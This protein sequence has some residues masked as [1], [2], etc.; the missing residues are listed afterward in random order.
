MHADT[1]SISS[2]PAYQLALSGVTGTNASGA[3][4][5]ILTA[6]ATSANVA[7]ARA[8]GVP[9][10]MPGGDSGFF[11]TAVATTKPSTASLTL[12]QALVAFPQYSGV[13]D[14]WGSNVENFSYN[15]LQVTVRQRLS[16]GLTFNANYT[17]SQNLGDDGSFR[18]GFRDS[19]WYGRRHD[20]ESFRQNRIDRGVTTIAQPHVFNFFG[21]Y[22]IPVGMHGHFLGENVITRSLFGNWSLSGI[23]QAASGTPVAVTSS[24]CTSTPPN[25]GTCMPSIAPGKTSARINGAYGSGPGGTTFS[26]LNSVRYIDPTAFVAPADLSTVPATAHQFKF[27]NAPRTAPFGLAQSGGEQYECL[28]KTHVPDVARNFAG[29]GGERTKR[30]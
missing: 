14:G 15:S 16:H 12:A 8:A 19:F 25:A 18:S 2:N 23:Y 4:V 21:V 7:K 10:N 3:T 26:N 27:G 13:T 22:Q 29:R 9:L 24:H 30:L 20:P 11:V 17:W 6:P 5:P 28:H 1:G